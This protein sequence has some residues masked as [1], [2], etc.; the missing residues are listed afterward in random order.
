MNTVL[1]L[2][3][4]GGFGARLCRRLAGDGWRV[5]VAGRNLDKARALAGSIPEAI[6]AQADRNGDLGPVL[7]QHNPLLVVD[8]AGPFQ[9]STYGVAESCIAHRFHYLDLADARDFVCA[10]GTLDDQARAADVTMI[11][12]ASSVPAL[13]G[14]V[15]HSLAQGFERVDEVRIAISASDRATAGTSVASAILSYVG[16]PVSLWKGQRPVE[17]AGFQHLSRLRLRMHDTHRFARR[18]ALADVPDLAIW[19]GELPGRPATL[20]HAGPEFGFQVLAVWLLSWPVRWRWIGSLKP[21]TALLMPLQTLTRR[22][23]DGRS[24]M[25]VELAG[26]D[27]DGLLRKRWELLA[28]NGLGPEIPVLAAQLLARRIA[29]GELET[30]A[31][32]AHAELALADF[33]EAFGELGIARATVSDPA[34]PL[35]RRVLGERFDILPDQ[36]RAM[37]EICGDGGASG[38]AS[39]ERG[40]NPLAQLVGWAM[41]FPAAGEYRLHVSFSETGGRERW[42]RDFGGQRFHSELSECR[43]RLTERFGPMRFAFELPVSADGL[44]MK[45]ARWTAFGMPMPLWLAPQIVAK[46]SV[47][48]GLFAFDVAIALPIV[49]PVV[50]YRGTLARNEGGNPSA[51]SPPL[52]FPPS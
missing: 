7:R 26:H 52:Q 33:E 49:G 23:S 20:F 6:A 44:E 14:A 46:E 25:I 42:T 48:D 8:A 50:R 10:I 51:G 41:R 35:Y 2:G 11:S 22:F 17:M 27:G 1:V 9:G 40:P 3:G 4:Y 29:S 39:V 21:L 16:K 34:T 5:V 28:R 38:T 47:E 30:G 13:S 15:I 19:P 31:R 32:N 24:A 37:H 12:G 45:I 36:V 18:V 43:G